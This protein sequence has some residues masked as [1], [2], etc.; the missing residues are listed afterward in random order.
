MRLAAAV[1]GSAQAV[2]AIAVTA[3]V[4]AAAAGVTMTVTTPPVAN[5]TDFV[6]SCGL[7][8]PAFRNGTFTLFLEGFPRE[9]TGRESRLIED[10]VVEA[11]NDVTTGD[12]SE[13]GCVDQYFREM[14]NSTF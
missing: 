12:Q 14:V 3:T 1:A 9:F 13:G 2:A 8:D 7:M 4:A 11:Y 10:L 6:S 5:A